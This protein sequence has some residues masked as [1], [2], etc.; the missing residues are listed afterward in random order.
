MVL[1]GS[2]VV[3]VA[4][5][6]TATREWQEPSLGSGV[7]LAAY[8]SVWYSWQSPWTTQLTVSLAGSTFDTTMAVYAFVEGP[9]AS[10]AS[11]Y[12]VHVQ[13]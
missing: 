2:S 5:T 3:A 9:T 4:S 8:K 11:L 10:L 13:M 7:N 12:Q 6:V 1:T